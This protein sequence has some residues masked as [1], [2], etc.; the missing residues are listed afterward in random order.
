MDVDIGKMAGWKGLC[1]HVNGYQI[2]GTSITAQDLGSIVS[3]SSIE[4]WPSTRLDELWFEQHMFNDKVSVRIGKLAIDSEFLIADSAAAFINSTFGWTTL[5]SDNLPFGGPIY[6]FASPGVRVRVEPSNRFKL[7]AGVYDDNPI[8]PCPE[9]L[10]PGQCNE[11]G[12][13]LR[14]NDPPLLLI[15]GDY[16]FKLGHA[17]LLGTIKLGGWR[18]FGKVD[19]Q[20]LDV[21]GAL[22]GVTG[23]APL[24]HDGDFA[25]YGVID[26]LIYRPPGD[27]D[28]K[29]I[30]VF[31][32]LIGSPSDR[33][34]IDAYADTGIRIRRHGAAPSKRCFR[35]RFC[36]HRHLQRCVGL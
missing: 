15:E 4:A 34:Q 6:P 5:S 17:G 30:S 16:S 8:G 23:A 19:D 1:F 12:L 31:A 14:L 10:D 28:A 9:D 18:D 3:A 2:Q 13:D 11:N 24:R 20:R 36:L 29:G 25:F 21:N 7:L 26:Q 32:R 27:G 33:N 22:L 35:N